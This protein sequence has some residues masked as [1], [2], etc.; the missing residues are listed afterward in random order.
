VKQALVMRGRDGRG[1]LARPPVR[2]LGGGLV[3]TEQHEREAAAAAAAAT[4][5]PVGDRDEPAA[6]RRVLVNPLGAVLSPY[7]DVGTP[8]QDPRRVP[9]K[10]WHASPGSSGR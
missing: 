1:V 6:R 5:L 10:L 9:R 7:A 8:G 4:G 3:V 2:E